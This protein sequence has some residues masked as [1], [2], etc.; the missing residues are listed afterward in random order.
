MVHL[1]LLLQLLVLLLQLFDL[2]LSLFALGLLVADVAGRA[3][4][5][6]AARRADRGTGAGR[7]DEG[8]DQRATR[9]ACRP[10]RCRRR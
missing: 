1:L 9:G 2:G 3:T 6:G 10:R 4:E 5:R 8:A 7:A